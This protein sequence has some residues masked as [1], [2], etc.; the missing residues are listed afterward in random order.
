MGCGETL[1]PSVLG[2][3]PSTGSVFLGKPEEQSLENRGRA[4]RGGCPVRM[5]AEDVAEG[6]GGTSNRGTAGTVGAVPPREGIAV[7][8]ASTLVQACW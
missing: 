1:G 7:A 6:T 8:R 5:A 3:V 2:R 4:C